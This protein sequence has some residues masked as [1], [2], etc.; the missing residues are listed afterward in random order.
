MVTKYTDTKK[1][2]IHPGQWSNNGLKQVHEINSDSFLLQQ[3]YLLHM[4]SFSNSEQCSRFDLF[5]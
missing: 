4:Y 1:L 3:L 2:Q 5:C